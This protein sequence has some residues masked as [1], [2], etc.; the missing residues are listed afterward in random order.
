MLEHLE[1]AGVRDFAG[2]HQNTPHQAGPEFRDG[3]DHLVRGKLAGTEVE[4]NR[5]KLILANHRQRMVSV[6]GSVTIVTESRQQ[7]V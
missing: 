2:D 7:H 6:G 5:V 1:G 3:A 4:Q